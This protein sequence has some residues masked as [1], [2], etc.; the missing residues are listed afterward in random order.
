MLY[1]HATD[2]IALVSGT[3][4]AG[5]AAVWLLMLTDVID[6]EQAWIGGPVILIV[7]GVLG[8]LVTLTPSRPASA[9]THGSDD[10]DA[11]LD[12]DD[13]TATDQP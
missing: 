3:I 5:L 8:L 6:I 12:R 11:P 9:D 10:G 7:A 4:F 1:R 13:D 2:V